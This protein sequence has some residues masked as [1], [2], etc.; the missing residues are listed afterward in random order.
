MKPW[1]YD[2]IPR[3]FN[4]GFLLY[5]N[6]N[7]VAFLE[8]KSFFMTKFYCFWGQWLWWKWDRFD[9]SKYCVDFIVTLKRNKEKTE[10]IS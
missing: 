9:N 8:F 1:K 7:E 5:L 6:A 4:K 10:E 2:I 3:P